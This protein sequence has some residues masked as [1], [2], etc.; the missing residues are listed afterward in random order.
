MST[1]KKPGFSQ[2]AQQAMSHMPL[3]SMVMIKQ[4]K[5]HL[6]IGIPKE[7]AYQE[8]RVGLSPSSV[9]LLVNNGHRVWIETMAGDK[10][11]FTDNDYSEAG[12]E[13]MHKKE[14][15]YKADIVLK[16]A[17][18]TLEEIEML[19]N[20]NVLISAIRHASV[21]SEYVAALNKKKITSL[22]YEYIRD[23]SGIF[24]IVRSMSE[25]VGN[26]CVLIAAEYLSNINDGKGMML[27]GI[28]GV[29]PTEVVIIGAGT[30]GEYATRAAIGLGAEVKVFDNSLYRLRRLQN[31]VGQRVFTSVIQPK[32]LSKALST[33][34]VAI[35]ALRPVKWRSPCVVS[36]EMVENMNEGAVIMD[37]SIDHGGCF[38]TS[39][40]TN[41]KNP[42][43]VKHGV[44]HY[45][46]P[47]IASRVSRT[48][49]YALTNVFAPILLD[50]AD[51][52]G[53]K[54]MLWERPGVRNGV[55][56]YQGNLTNKYLAEVFEI[57][58][59]DL[60]LLMAARL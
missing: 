19:E 46:V 17:P 43:F 47:N 3:E 38:E 53:I 13:I 58:Y 30:V 12:A 6:L 25:L 56:T 36:E 32:V 8:K 21:T 5:K 44:I 35:G 15:V 33:C 51:L 18:P 31:D 59:K 29:P 24:P 50:V 26:T 54:N 4:S 49:S 16:V 23:E 1:E 7:V 41:H 55:Y 42:I 22:A 34:D 48:A 28:S 27:G 9:N 14:E 37:V 20:G 39:V 40:P 2:L 45:C 52:G 60:D 57:P 10:A 11:N